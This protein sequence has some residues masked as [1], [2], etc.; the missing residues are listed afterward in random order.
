MLS[1]ELGVTW[2]DKGYYRSS[3]NR[4]G[5]EGGDRRMVGGAGRI[6]SD[7]VQADL[8]VAER[9]RHLELAAEGFHVAPQ[10][11]H[12]MVVSALDV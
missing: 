4:A 1:V 2:T 5:G 3:S 7:A 9:G 11:R 8:L 6:R 10:R 12:K